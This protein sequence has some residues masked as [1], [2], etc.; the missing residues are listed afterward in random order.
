VKVKVSVNID[1]TIYEK[2]H[3][4]GINVS[5]AS[6][7]YLKTLIE[8]IENTTLSVNALQEQSLVRSPGFEPGSST[9]QGP[10]VVDWQA[11]ENWMVTVKKYRGSGAKTKLSYATRYHGLLF[12]GE[13]GKV[14]ELTPDSKA[15]ALKALS[16]L[17]EFLG[18]KNLFKKEMERFNLTWVGKSADKIF[19][20]R[21]TKVKDPEEIFSWIKTAKL[22]KLELSEFLD[23]MAITG[24]RLVE[25]VEAYN[26]IIR[27]GK[28]D[29]LSEY[30]NGANSS[31]E[32]F[33]FEGLFIRK[34]K[35][36]FVSFVP[37]ALIEAIAKH[38]LIASAAS[39]SKSLKKAGVKPRFAD[40]RENHG[41]YM[42]RFL[43]ENEIN[44]LH[45]RVTNGVFMQH[46]FN[47]S[48]IGDLRERVFKGIAE[49]QEKVDS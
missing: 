37:A 25:A 6:E 3:S 22:A 46:Y 17:C 23:L 26:L 1:K 11:F 13:L 43:N 38:A 7:N 40:I 10:T 24:L 45:G 35:K 9:W 41:S 16:V 30:F 42:L 18:F 14:A 47:P 49:I 39:V 27:L 36:A 28:Q 44:F 12:R 31:L 2:A 21:L 34:S 19:M 32:H 5:K 8:A 33:K 29:K 15:N 48:L 4:L 20:E